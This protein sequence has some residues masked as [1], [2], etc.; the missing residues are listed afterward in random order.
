MS[1]YDD[2]IDIEMAFVEKRNRGTKQFECV[3]EVLVCPDS[4]C[5]C[6]MI[7][8]LGDSWEEVKS[9]YPTFTDIMEQINSL[10]EISRELNEIRIIKLDGDEGLYDQ[11]VA[12]WNS[13]IKDDV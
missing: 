3:L 5:P 8:P 2:V 10:H 12:E 7:Y 6:Q 11:S 1:S 9:S 4:P 13:N